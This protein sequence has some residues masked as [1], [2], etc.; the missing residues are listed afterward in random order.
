M[1][2]WSLIICR[3]P[4]LLMVA[5]EFA[6]WTSML[7][8]SFCFA[9]I[10]TP[11]FFLLNQAPSL[12]KAVSVSPL[13]EASR[14]FLLINWLCLRKISCLLL[15]STFSIHLPNLIM[16]S[17]KTRYQACWT[18]SGSW[19]KSCGV[20]SSPFASKISYKVCNSSESKTKSSLSRYWF[21]SWDDVSC[22]GRYDFLPSWDDS[23]DLRRN[24]MTT[25]WDWWVSDCD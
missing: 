19:D 7:L 16:S 12:D 22:D 4:C 13:W 3:N 24:C 25:G 21:K 14:I 1:T 20:T 15:F 6:I 18:W 9:A 17:S 5:D 8:L 11:F 2:S 23:A 10:P